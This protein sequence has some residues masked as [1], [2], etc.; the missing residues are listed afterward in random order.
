MAIPTYEEFFER[1]VIDLLEKMRYGGEL[2]S[3]GE[4]TGKTGDEGD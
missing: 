3:P 2:V 1:L 4:V